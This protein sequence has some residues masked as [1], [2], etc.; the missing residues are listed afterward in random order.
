[1]LK[2]LNRTKWIFQLHLHQLVFRFVISFFFFLLQAIDFYV[3]T[4]I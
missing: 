4:Y 1:M 3:V 2:I